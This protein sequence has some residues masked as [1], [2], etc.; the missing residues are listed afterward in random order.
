MTVHVTLELLKDKL[1]SACLKLTIG[2]YDG[3]WS[4]SKIEAAWNNVIF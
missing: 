3:C 4:P 2:N 1:R